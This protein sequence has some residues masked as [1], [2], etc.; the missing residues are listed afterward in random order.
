MS[1]V[2]FNGLTGFLMAVSASKISDKIPGEYLDIVVILGLV[3][4]GLIVVMG[5]LSI[6]RLLVSFTKGTYKKD[7]RDEAAYSKPLTGYTGQEVVQGPENDPQ[8]VAVITA[9]IMAS[10]EDA[11]ADGLVIRSIRR[12]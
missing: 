3:F 2:G 7:G 10:M 11:P 8:L 12:K 9:A 5:I 1:L 6:I 4:I